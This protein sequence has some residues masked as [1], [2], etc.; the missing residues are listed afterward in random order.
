MHFEGSEG[1]R[2]MSREKVFSASE[3]S[4][5]FGLRISYT[6]AMC[7][8]QSTLSPFPLISHIPSPHFP[9]IH[10]FMWLL[11]FLHPL[12]FTSSYLHALGSRTTFWDMGSLQEP[13]PWRK[14]IP[15]SLN[16]YQLPVAPQLGWL[17]L[18]DAF[19]HPH[20]DF[21]LAALIL[22]SSCASGHS[23]CELTCVFLDM[24][25]KHCSAVDFY[26]VWLL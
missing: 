3:T 8:D 12:K 21:F 7:C 20:R 5:R 4:V 26:Y 10:E 14:L 13:H 19:P 22:W 6:F 1:H 17:A 16:S 11:S 18:D 15:S 9:Q 25:G 2:W 23:P 24:S